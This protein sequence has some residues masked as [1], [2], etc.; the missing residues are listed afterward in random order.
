ME[1]ALAE[2]FGGLGEVDGRGFEDGGGFRVTDGVTGDAVEA[3]V[4]ADQFLAVSDLLGVAGRLGDL[5]LR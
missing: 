4:G 1:V 5:L 2:A 3:A